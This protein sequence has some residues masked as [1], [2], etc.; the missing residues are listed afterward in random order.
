MRNAGW[1]IHLQLL[2]LR[3]GGQDGLGL[4]DPRPRLGLKLLELPGGDLLPGRVDGHAVLAQHPANLV[5]VAL[6]EEVA[7]RLQALKEA[8]IRLQ[9]EMK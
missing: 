3:L 1:Q 8:L 2:V 4:L 7:A 6:L 5:L 9:L